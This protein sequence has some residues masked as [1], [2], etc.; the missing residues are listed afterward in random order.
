ME[1]ASMRW[2]SSG[3]A[4][5][6]L[7]R[8]DFVTI[9]LVLIIPFVIIPALV[10]ALGPYLPQTWPR[11]YP[12]LLMGFLVFVGITVYMSLTSRT[13]HYVLESVDG[14]FL[15]A[16]TNL[17]EEI[18][19]L[20]AIE[21]V[22]TIVRFWRFRL[23]RITVAQK[24]APFSTC[25]YFTPDENYFKSA[26]FRQFPIAA[27]N[28]KDFSDS[29]SYGRSFTTSQSPHGARMFVE[30]MVEISSKKLERVKN[31]IS[32]MLTYSLILCCILIL[33]EN[34]VQEV[35]WGFFFVWAG[36]AILD[37]IFLPMQLA[38][39]VLESADGKFLYVMFYKRSDILLR[40]EIQSV[41]CVKRRGRKWIEV[42]HKSYTFSF[43]PNENYFKSALFRQFPI[44]DFYQ[45]NSHV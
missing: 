13:A 22:D 9:A 21:S 17:R 45:E 10:I 37:A 26:L 27:R 1:N 8:V 43:R 29:T 25:L 2:I 14:M 41:V 24:F 4:L 33:F 30:S 11:P 18:I 3:K 5:K 32:V 28:L 36:I 44:P 35:G 16:K 19:P 31:F 34:K 7:R 39:N 15:R 38:H 20:A 42:R 23:L 6:A 12:I 40:S